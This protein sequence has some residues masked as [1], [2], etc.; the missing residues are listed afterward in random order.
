MR[1][2]TIGTCKCSKCGTKNFFSMYSLQV[3][4]DDEPQK[5]EQQFYYSCRLCCYPNFLKYKQLPESMKKFT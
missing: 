3:I 2:T 5:E 4:A 1:V